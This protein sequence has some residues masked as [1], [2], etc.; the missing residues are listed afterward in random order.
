MAIYQLD[1]STPDIHDSAWVADSAHVMGKVSLAQDS[2][3]WFGVVLRGDVET[4][5][6][7]RGSNIQDNSVLHAD[8]GIP[9]VIGDN[10][11]VG[12][13]VMLHGCTIGD[14]SL[15]GIQAVVLNGAKIGKNCLV[16]AGSLVTEG[17]EFP[18]GSMILGSP[19]KAVRQLTPEQIEG[20][21]MSA[22]HY[23]DNA[24]RY[25]TGLKKLA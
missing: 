7:G 5:Q 11:T 21:K 1:D 17:K 4:I 20:L 9:L 23:I 14:G 19:A 2:S 15:I 13:Q 6:V 16:G 10:V 3:I 25:K 12:H 22:Q 18:D 8:H 24:R